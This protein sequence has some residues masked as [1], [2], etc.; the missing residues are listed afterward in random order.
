MFLGLQARLALSP[1]TMDYTTGDYMSAWLYLIPL[2]LVTATQT[3]MRT[4]NTR[5]KTAADPKYQF[6]TQILSD[7]SWFITWSLVSHQIFESIENS[8]FPL[9]L[10]S[11]FTY[12]LAAGVESMA[13]FAILIRWERGLR[14]PGARKRK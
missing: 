12:T 4:W 13:T 14:R 3:G 6:W 2:F 9:F 11:W 10:A 1:W 8:N 7:G 5:A